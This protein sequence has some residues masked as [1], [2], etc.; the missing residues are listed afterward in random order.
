MS[1]TKMADN[2]EPIEGQSQSPA[3]PVARKRH[4]HEQPG[5]ALSEAK[6]SSN[7]ASSTKATKSQSS[8]DTSPTRPS[9]QIVMCV[10]GDE[11]GSRQFI[12][13]QRGNGTE[14]RDPEAKD[15]NTQIICF[16]IGVMVAP[17]VAEGAAT[18]SSH[19]T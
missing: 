9:R 14:C 15:R 17:S 2:Q 1:A 7:V 16:C 18:I 11:P 19:T 6:T 4:Y 12:L 10:S 5:P 13:I 8:Y 3:A